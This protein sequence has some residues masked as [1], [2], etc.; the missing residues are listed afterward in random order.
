MRKENIND[1]FRFVLGPLAKELTLKLCG[2]D[3]IPNSEHLEAGI[4]ALRR[5]AE[6][7]AEVNRRLREEFDRLDGRMMQLVSAQNTGMRGLVMMSGQLVRE[8]SVIRK[9]LIVT[10]ATSN[11]QA[12]R[13]FDKAEPAIMEMRATL[14]LWRQ[15]EGLEIPEFS[16]EEEGKLLEHLVQTP[17]I[18]KSHTAADDPETLGEALTE[19]LMRVKE[20]FDPT[21]T[22]ERHDR[23]MEHDDDDR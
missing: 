1:R 22:Q 10:G 21:L 14:A 6:V 2:K 5:D 19:T 9:L 20:S 13:L 18:E 3:E 8:L 23:E 17:T 4:K 16:L 12:E 7:E 15:R 11:E